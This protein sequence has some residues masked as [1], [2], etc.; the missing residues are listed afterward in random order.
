MSAQNYSPLA[1]AFS[2]FFYQYINVNNDVFVFPDWYPISNVKGV[3]IEKLRQAYRDNEVV[4]LTEIEMA[5]N[6][7]L[8][9]VN[10]SYPVLLSVFLS[11]EWSQ[12]ELDAMLFGFIKAVFEDIDLRP[13]IMWEKEIVA[14]FDILNTIQVDFT[15]HEYEKKVEKLFLVSSQADRDLLT[16]ISRSMTK[17]ANKNASVKYDYEV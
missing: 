14:L 5:N 6:S 8:N 17:S 13:L 4:K 9:K 12:E 7:F 3:K 16:R 15:N 10:R 2:R 1:E 11:V